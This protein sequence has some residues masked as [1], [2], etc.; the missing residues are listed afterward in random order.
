MKA[1]AG[2]LG[3]SIRT[4]YHNSII[5][6]ILPRDLT[7]NHAHFIVHFLN[8]SL[9][10]K[11]VKIKHGHDSYARAVI[12]EPNTGHRDDDLLAARNV[13]YV[14]AKVCSGTVDSLLELFELLK[15]EE[16]IKKLTYR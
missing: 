5:K 16:I 12:T 2:D 8:R 15:E 3:Y 14:S 9:S 6:I 10:S 11:K 13:I 1:I 7:D 4:S